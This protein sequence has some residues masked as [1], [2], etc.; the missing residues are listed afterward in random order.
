[1]PPKR[2][3]ILVRK[4]VFVAPMV[5]TGQSG[6]GRGKIAPWSPDPERP[7]V[8]VQRA[9]GN[10]AC[11]AVE[12]QGVRCLIQREN[13]AGWVDPFER[14]RDARC[15]RCDQNGVATDLLTSRPWS[16]EQRQPRQ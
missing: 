8:M 9:F 1:V 2:K 16:C 10:R 15:E 12:R 14:L 13:G 6:S 5:A 4:S 3:G 11:I 7:D